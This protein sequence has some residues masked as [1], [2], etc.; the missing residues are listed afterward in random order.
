MCPTPHSEKDYEEDKEVLR[1][2]KERTALMDEDEL[3][4]E[5]EGRKT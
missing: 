5:F 4:E 2:L 3:I 1:L